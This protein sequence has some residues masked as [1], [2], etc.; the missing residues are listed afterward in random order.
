MSLHEETGLHSDEVVINHEVETFLT[1]DWC[2]DTIDQ[3]M[4][5]LGHFDLLEPIVS[6]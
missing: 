2:D 1:K 5:E 3:R 6:C 4:N